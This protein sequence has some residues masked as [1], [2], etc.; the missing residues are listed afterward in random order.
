ML[1]ISVGDL[2]RTLAAGK[3]DS[4]E[5][6]FAEI[7]RETKLIIVVEPGQLHESILQKVQSLED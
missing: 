5:V 3:P 1:R 2:A 6:S 7:R 4:Y